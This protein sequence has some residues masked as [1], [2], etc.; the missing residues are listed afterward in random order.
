MQ[1]KK[2]IT[3]II[4]GSC[5]LLLLTG[6]TPQSQPNLPQSNQQII[7]GKSRMAIA[8]LIDTVK[9]VEEQGTINSNQIEALSKNTKGLSLALEGILARINT[10]EQ[11]IQGNSKLAQKT[12]TVPIVTPSSVE[13]KY[14]VIINVA[15]RV[16]AEKSCER[17]DVFLKGHSF[18]GSDNGNGWVKTRD[19]LYVFGKY[20][21]LN[22]KEK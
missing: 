11:K 14:I 17:K 12:I 4:Y 19:N 6:C 22:S 9:E 1:T 15:A 18:L 2:L 7:D 21:Q 8:A 3:T 10:I 20:V 5:A 16:C 13:E